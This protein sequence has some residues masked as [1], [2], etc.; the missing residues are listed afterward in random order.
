ESES[1]EAVLASAI[2]KPRLVGHVRLP[3]FLRP[4]ACEREQSKYVNVHSRSLFAF[5]TRLATHAV[6]NGARRTKGSRR[7][8]FA[9][10]QETWNARRSAWAF[11]AFRRRSWRAAFPGRASEVGVYEESAKVRAEPF[12][13]IELDLG[14]L[15]A[16]V[17]LGPPPA[18]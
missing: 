18:R 6:P 17:D 15:W 2:T 12:D 11:G 10:R 8:S 4:R 3:A 16:D 13:A 1:V 5:L 7:W 9:F 14:L